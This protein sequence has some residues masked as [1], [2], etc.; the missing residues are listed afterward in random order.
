MFRIPLFKI[1][2]FSMGNFANFLAA[3]GRGGMMFILIIW[4]Q[5]IWL[6]EHGYSFSQTPLWAGIYMVPLTVGFLVAGPVSGF[7]SDRFGARPFATGGMILAAV[8]F[9]LLE[10]LPI[11]FPYVAFAPILLLNGVAM[12]VFASPNRAGVMNALPPDQRGAGAGMV[13]TF[14][15]SAQ[16][17]SIGI[18]FTLIILGLA[19]E[20]PGSLY[21]GLVAH[22]VPT[23][24]ALRVSHL[25]PVGSLF[26]AFL[27]YN[28]MEKLL[29]VTTLQHLPAAT[30]HFLTGRSFFPGLIAAPFKKGLNLAFDFAIVSCLLAAGGRRPC[31]AAST[32]TAR[33]T[34]PK[35]W[36]PSWRARGW[37]RP[38]GRTADGVKVKLT[39]RVRRTASGSRGGRPE[40]P[41]QVSR[42]ELLGQQAVEPGGIAAHEAPAQG[43][44][45]DVAGEIRPPRG[46]DQELDRLGCPIAGQQA[47][48]GNL[49][50]HHVGSAP[51]SCRRKAAFCL[52]PPSASPAADTAPT[53]SVS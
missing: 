4:L 45:L 16:V 42:R 17:L 15:N 21:H 31:G 43:Q 41:R 18:F 11:D 46:M 38:T 37:R 26:A 28:P 12:G 23:R 52:T 51:S 35:G 33:T 13:N 25:P 47:P 36:R 32:S 8:S 34:W 5:G 6:P 9:L 44:A 22:G 27:G 20:L 48:A 53:T 1:R 30:A 7:L 49:V 24:D 50:D 3:L 19:S 40:R 2:A 39:V 10:T 14:Q 29:G